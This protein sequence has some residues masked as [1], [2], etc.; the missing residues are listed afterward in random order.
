[1]IDHLAGPGAPAASLALLAW[2][3]P[4]LFAAVRGWLG[5]PYVL[6]TIH[7]ALALATSAHVVLFKRDGRAAVAWVGVIW[8]APP[9]VGPLLYFIF[10]I[11]RIQRRA[12]R[13]RATGASPQDLFEEGAVLQQRRAGADG[14][15]TVRRRA[16]PADATA[17]RRRPPSYGAAAGDRRVEAPGGV[18]AEQ[19][20]PA[21]GG[22]AADQ[23][24]PAPGAATADQ[25]R[26][27][28]GGA[29]TADHYGLAALRT[30][31]GNVTGRE[32][33]HGNRVEP[34]INGDEAYPAML[35]A[36]TAAERSIALST[37]IFDHDRAGERFV[38]ALAAAHERGVTVRV[39]VDGVGV[40][41]SRPRI[42]RSLQ[43]RGVPFAKFLEP[44]LPPRS[45]YLNLRTHRKILVVDGRVGFTGGLNIREGCILELEPDYPV[46]DMH[47]RLEGPVV[48]HLMED[49]SVDW[50]FTT[51]ELLEGETWYPTLEAA[52]SVEARGIAAGPDENFETV[53]W[54]LLGALSAAEVSVRI[55]TPYFIPDQTLIAAL[56]L[57]ALRGVSVEIVLPEH[58]NLRFVQ[59]ASTAQLWQV[60]INGCKVF[61]SP[62]PFDHCKLMVV[63]GEWVFVGSSN[64]DAR[65]LR[66]NFEYN[67][68]CYDRAL[69]AEI[70]RIIDDKIAAARPTSYEEINARSRPVKLRDGIVRLAAPYL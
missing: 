38:E 33:T 59:W 50:E 5:W 28:P 48:E 41:Y 24:Q 27:A 16:A 35:E 17:H 36:I 23:R 55:T 37:F 10:G 1:M 45:S 22:A 53:Y 21:P 42:T 57:A 54:T 63:D 18:A 64:W 12:S 39:L 25:R 66:L 44:V 20:R 56:N 49:F 47:F 11:N 40:R 51:G 31:V 69:A 30:C 67:V 14:V 3:W 32:L 13:L 65:S 29:A 43:A 70:N 68:E 6:A 60:L 19:R 26:P 2:G 34:L 7:V 58:G 62:P 61:F 9:A 46:Q 8:L 52:G 4:D 15:T